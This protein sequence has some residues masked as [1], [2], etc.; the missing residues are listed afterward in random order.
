[1]TRFSPASFIW[2]ILAS[3]LGWT[4]GPFFRLLLI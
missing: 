4:K 2:R 1:M 3:S